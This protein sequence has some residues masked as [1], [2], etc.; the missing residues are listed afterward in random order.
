MWNVK[1]LGMFKTM[2]QLLATAEF[3]S[4]LTENIYL[5]LTI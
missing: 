4:N 2:K 3:G 5:L 1:T